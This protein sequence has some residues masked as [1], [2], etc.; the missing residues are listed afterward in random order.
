LGHCILNNGYTLGYCEDVALV[1]C[2]IT[3]TLAKYTSGYSRN[4]EINCSVNNTL[5]VIAKGTAIPTD[6]TWKVGDKIENTNPAAGGYMGWVCVT[7]GSPGAWKGYG[8]IQA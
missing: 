5:T 1:D 7:A 3:W 6:G 8:I 4:T 2:Q